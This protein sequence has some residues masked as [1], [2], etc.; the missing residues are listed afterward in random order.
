MTQETLSSLRDALNTIRGGGSLSDAEGE[1]SYERAGH[2]S[3]FGEGAEELRGRCVAVLT[4]DQLSTALA[5]LE[6]DGFARRLVVYPHEPVLDHLPFVLRASGV[7]AIVTNREDA[8]TEL[9]GIRV[10]RPCRNPLNNG[11]ERSAAFETEWITFTSGTTGPPKLVVHTLRSLI[12]ALQ[13]TGARAPGVVWGTL[14]D[15]RRFGGMQVFFRAVLAGAS[16]V[17]P[18]PEEP[19][20]SY[21]ARAGKLGVTH[22]SG[23]PSQWRRLLMSG[24]AH[25][26]TPEYVRLSGEIADQALLNRL[27]HTYPRTRIVHAFGSNEAGTVFEVNDGLA[28]FPVETMEHPWKVEMKIEDQTL[29]VRSSRTASRY[30]GEGAP[31]LKDADGFVDT[32]DMVELYDGR[33]AFIGRRDGRINVGGLKV[34]PEEVEAVINRHPEVH[35]SLVRAKKSPVT[36]AVV[37]AEVVLNRPGKGASREEQDLESQILG[38]CREHLPLHKVPVAIRFVHNVAMGSSG[39]VLRNRG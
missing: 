23:T 21:L 7:E 1:A 16:L 15:I 33:Y 5:L 37:V 27:R 36:G 18:S 32:G 28:G 39:K 30:L 6:L 25:A 13:Y 26:I 35:V 9:N 19:I 24:A 8:P 38:F 31:V 3:I 11:R 17:L 20:E 12:G 34:Y 29:R 4:R 10:V 14:Y 22:M 2:G